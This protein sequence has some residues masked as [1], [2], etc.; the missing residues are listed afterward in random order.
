MQLFTKKINKLS[1]VFQSTI[2]N[3]M[4]TNRANRRCSPVIPK[5]ILGVNS[6][7]FSTL[8]KVFPGKILVDK[9][10]GCY[11]NYFTNSVGNTS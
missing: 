9:G 10:T 5:V 1:Q 3:Q 2:Y 7:V 8:H 6:F 4:K 11:D